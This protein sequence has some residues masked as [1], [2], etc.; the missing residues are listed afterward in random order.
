VSTRECGTG[1]RGLNGL[2]T[3]ARGCG[4]TLRAM[5]GQYCKASAI[6]SE[7][8]EDF[9]D[10]GGAAAAMLDRI[11][12]RAAKDG[13]HELSSARVHGLLMLMHATKHA[14]DGEIE[15]PVAAA[16]FS[17]FS[18]EIFASHGRSEDARE[19]LR[20]DFA[21]MDPIYSSALDP[22][23]P[24]PALGICEVFCDAIGTPWEPDS[25]TAALVTDCWSEYSST[26]KRFLHDVP[27]F[28]RLV[29]A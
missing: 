15:R 25:E 6:G 21:R 1:K 9:C 3:L 26:V 12:E 24:V 5:A 13:A 2:E 4:G 18:R 20:Q 27:S 10:P 23:S 7:L 16:M 28:C 8:A 29:P 19:A 22:R 14:I 17:G 11:V